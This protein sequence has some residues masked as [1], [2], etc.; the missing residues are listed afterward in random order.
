MIFATGDFGV[1]IKAILNRDGGTFKTTDMAAY[2]EKA[3]DIFG[4][5]GHRL[6][7]FVV[8]GKEMAGALE[9]AAHRD[10]LDAILAGGGDGTISAA[11]G[12]AWKNGMPLGVI[13][14]GTMN[15]FARSLGLPLDIWQVLPVLACGHLGDADIGSADG[16]AFVHQFSAGM[17]ARMVRYRNQIAYSSRAGKIAANV[18]ASIGVVLNP[19]EFEVEFDVDGHRE[20][21]MISAISVSNNPFAENGLM[22]SEDITT[23]HLGFYV[24]DPLRPAS[25]AK[26]AVDIL[27]G[28]MKANATITEMTGRAVDLHFPK[29]RHGTN[30]VLDGEL[31]PLGRDVSIRLHPGELKV[32]VPEDGPIAAAQ[33]GQDRSGA[34]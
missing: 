18:R 17:H 8:S 29:F 13:P 16:R 19:P 33:A 23:G 34:V 3:E 10:D 24:T 26:L 32:I 30:F 4:E 1:K 5:A 11:A 7:V 27:R 31:L 12:I 22:Y 15:L 6:E 9:Q 21:R 28:R 14:A 25:A 20:H 2:A